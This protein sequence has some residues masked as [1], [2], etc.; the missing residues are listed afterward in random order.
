MLKDVLTNDLNVVFCGTAK[1]KASAR[2]GYY[3]A[4]PGNKF[5][6]ILYSAGFTPIRL[7]PEHCYQINKYKI[8]LTDLVHNQAGNDK[9]INPDNYDVDGFIKK[10]KLFKPRYVGFT[11]KAAASYALGFKGVTSL[12]DYGIQ[13]TQIGESKIFVLPS[14]SGSA[15][16]YWDEKYWIELKQRID[17]TINV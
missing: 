7:M 1:G 8:G 14:T 13:N 11:S 17:S 6:S 15:R 9:D 16:R 4:G 5:Y 2:L 10:I 3:Y 12:I